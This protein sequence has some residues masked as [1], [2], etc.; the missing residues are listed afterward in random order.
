MFAD[1]LDA[2]DEAIGQHLAEPVHVLVTG[3][4][5]MAGR[6]FVEN[7]TANRQASAA[8][9]GIGLE[10]A[11]PTLTLQYGGAHGV[12]QLRKGDRVA[13][14]PAF[15][16]GLHGRVWEVAETPARPGDGRWWVVRVAAVAVP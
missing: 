4:A 13:P 11:V 12:R 14:D 3:A 7:P 9:A 6:G 10:V 8:E 5:P 1:R 2:L 15:P 16:A